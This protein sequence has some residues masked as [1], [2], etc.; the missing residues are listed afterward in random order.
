MQRCEK[1]LTK[2]KW[3]EIIKS[4]IGNNQRMNC[5]ECD[6]EHFI[7]TS[8]KVIVFLM[9]LAIIT[10]TLFLIEGFLYTSFV[11]YLLAVLISVGIP[12]FLFPFIAKFKSKYHTNYKSDY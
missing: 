5:K 3:S 10:L 1:C 2:F 8:S 12:S 6:T 7:E 4:P 9:M 11:Y